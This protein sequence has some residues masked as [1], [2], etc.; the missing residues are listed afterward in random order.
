MKWCL[1]LVLLSIIIIIIVYYYYHY[2]Y[3]YYHSNP[4]SIIILYRNRGVFVRVYYAGY[5]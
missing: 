5:V 4:F 3:Y 2:Y 1:L